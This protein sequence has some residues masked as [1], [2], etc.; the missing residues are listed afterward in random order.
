MSIEHRKSERL[1]AEYLITMRIEGEPPATAFAR[2]KMTNLSRGGLCFL[3]PYALKKDQKL[4]ID[5][6]AAE[7]VVKLSAS[8]V[9]CRP[10]RDQYSTGAEFI[11]MSDALRTRLIE[12]HRAIVEYQKMNSAS[13]MTGMDAQ[14]AA[15]EWLTLYAK[16]FLAGVT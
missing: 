6:P 7:P 12:M 8:V 9:W 15:A 11:G 1:D 2:G 5:F 16:S 14:Q 4:E 3:G 10:Q 13:G